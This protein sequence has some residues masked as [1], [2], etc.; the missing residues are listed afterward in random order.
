VSRQGGRLRTPHSAQPSETT[1]AN[2]PCEMQMFAE[3]NISF[4]RHTPAA[5]TDARCTRFDLIAFCRS[6]ANREAL[7]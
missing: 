5:P 3:R 1:T 2:G 7:E 6:L 4:E